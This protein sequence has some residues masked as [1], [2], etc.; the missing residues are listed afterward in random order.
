EN[1]VGNTTGACAFD[2]TV[3]D[4]PGPPPVT[5]TVHTANS[6]T[7]AP[8]GGGAGGGIV[9]SA[10]KIDL[11]GTTSGELHANGGNGQD[12][13]KAPSGGGGG[14]IV[15]LLGPVQLYDAGFTPGTSGGSAG[16]NTC[17]GVDSPSLEGTTA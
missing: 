7:A 5:H 8:R 14:G 16:T 6:G 3:V 1:G 13:K 10:A 4:D 9:I 2:T 17:Q 15:K 12:S 11:R